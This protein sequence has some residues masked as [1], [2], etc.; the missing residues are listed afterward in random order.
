MGSYLMNNLH[1]WIVETVIALLFNFFRKDRPSEALQNPETRAVGVYLSFNFGNTS[2][3]FPAK[4]WKRDEDQY[5][6]VSVVSKKF[7]SIA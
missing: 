2:Y 1:L 4:K 7:F 6:W 3:R 5:C